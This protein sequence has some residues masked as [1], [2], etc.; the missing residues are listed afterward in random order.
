MP[1]NSVGIIYNERK[2]WQTARQFLLEA[3]HRDTNWAI[4]Y[5]NL[6]TSYF[7]EKNDQQAWSYYQQA[8]ERAPNW[9][10]P[11]AWLGDLAMRKKDYGVA[12]EEYQKVLDLSHADNTSLDLNEIRKR[13]DQAKSKSQQATAQE[14]LV[15]K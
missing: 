9:A 5:N 7:F 6:G 8:V 12:V 13:L 10:R 4:P 15:D 1:A 3:I 14:L 11:H 2:E